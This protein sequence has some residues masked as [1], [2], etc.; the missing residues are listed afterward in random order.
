[1]IT[2]THEEALNVLGELTE[3]GRCKNL[4]AVKVAALAKLYLEFS[5]I[6]NTSTLTLIVSK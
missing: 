6:G 3:P 4:S 1:M 5:V 2:L